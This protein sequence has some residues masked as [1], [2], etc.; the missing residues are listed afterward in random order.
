MLYYL[1]LYHIPCP[2]TTANPRIDTENLLLK[3]IFLK[4]FTI[5]ASTVEVQQTPSNITSGEYFFGLLWREIV[6][7]EDMPA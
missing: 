4:L 7:R 5:L 3:T 6:L 2:K 1:P